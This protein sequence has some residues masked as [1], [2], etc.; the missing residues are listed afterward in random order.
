MPLRN[1]TMRT[2]QGCL[3]IF[4][5]RRAPSYWFMAADASASPRRS[6]EHTSEL[7]SQSNLVCR[8]L[9]EK[10][11]HLCNSSALGSGPPRDI[12]TPITRCP[13]YTT[14]HGLGW[15][16]SQRHSRRPLLVVLSPHLPT[17]Q[18][19][20]REAGECDPH[21]RVDGGSCIHH[22]LLVCRRR[23]LT[24][25]SRRPAGGNLGLAELIGG[26]GVFERAVANGIGGSAGT[27]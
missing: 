26:I 15:P 14:C 3:R 24:T 1:C 20:D 18:G 2:W 7:Q 5:A 6:E 11:Q 21:G 16:C 23:A 4:A 25:G 17:G 9:L 13:E 22:S 12:S 10:K 8:L 19:P 27:I